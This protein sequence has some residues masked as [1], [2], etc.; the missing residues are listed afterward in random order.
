MSE[1][2]KFSDSAGVPWEGR[3]FHQNPFSSDNGEAD[4]ELLKAL[5]D[6]KSAS[7]NQIEV[8][9]AFANARVL[10]PLIA[11]LGETGEGAHGHKVD[12]SAELSIVSVRT[13]DNQIALP[14][15]T[16]VQ[17]ML[18]WNAQA[19]PVPN[20]GRTVALAAVS[21]GNT[22]IVLDPGS[23]TEFVIRR[24][25]LEAVAQGLPWVSPN[26][27]LE[28][29]GIV[30]SALESIVEVRNFTL[31][32]ADPRAT[33]LGPELEIVIYLAADLAKSRLD[34]IQ[35]EILRE[36]SSSRRFIELVDSVGLKFLP[37]N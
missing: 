2:D 5:L 4:P 27:N 22:R 14:A 28:V 12:K 6:F 3:S 8:L 10:I 25:A 30:D 18:R 32:D 11:A 17:S 9:D 26:L 23:E 34:E 20:N 13:P 37:A 35:S 16:S 19:R 1:N 33:L 24:P 36:I 21:E 15:F 7:S 29:I 31:I